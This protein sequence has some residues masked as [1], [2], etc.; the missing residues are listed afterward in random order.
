MIREWV[1]FSGAT[2]YSFMTIR[3]ISKL[4]EFD[5]HLLPETYRK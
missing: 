4:H 1:F 3:I 5:L 2:I